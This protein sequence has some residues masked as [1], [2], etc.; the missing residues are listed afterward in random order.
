[1]NDVRE[2]IIA[3]GAGMGAIAALSGAVWYVIVLC[4]RVHSLWNDRENAKA[5]QREMD[6]MR[7]KLEL[8]RRLQVD[9]G[10]GESIEAGVIGIHKPQEPK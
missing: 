1:V 10:I 7:D 3:I 2:W 9:R 6:I 5:R 8:M 4:L